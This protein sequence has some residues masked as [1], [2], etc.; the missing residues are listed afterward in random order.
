MPL[1]GEMPTDP[2]S[3]LGN[4]FA[5]AATTLLLVVTY[6][7]TFFATPG[8]PAPADDPAYGV[9]RTEA[10]LVEEPG[11]VMNIDGP[12]SM[13]STGYRI[14]TPV[15][16]ALMR[17]ILSVDKMTPSAVFAV[18]CRVVIALLLAG[19]AYLHL[20]DIAVWHVV[21]IG[22]GS[23]LLTP[24]FGGYT[25]NMIA[26]ALVT[27]SLYLLEPA[28][29]DWGARLAFTGLLT[30]AG[31]AHPTTLV[32][33]SATLV[34]IALLGAVLDGDRRAVELLGVAAAA[35]ILLV[36][37]RRGLWGPPA[38]LKEAALPPPGTTGFFMTRLGE[39]LA[40]I[41]PVPNA[42]LLGC[43]VAGLSLRTRSNSTT[44]ARISLA[45]LAPLIGV[46][47]AITSLAYPYYRFFNSTLAW[48]LLIG[49]G[50]YFAL[51]A[52]LRLPA[53]G[54]VLGIAA[55]LA[56]IGTNFAAG[57]TRPSWNDPDH[58]WITPDERRDLDALSAHLGNGTPDEVIFV[59]DTDVR[60]PVRLYGFVKR[61]GN[62]ARY[63]VPGALQSR[64]SIYLGSVENLLAGRATTSDPYY[65]RLSQA[66]LEE[67]DEVDTSVD[68]VV[69]AEVF[70]RSG[71]NAETEPPAGVLSVADGRVSQPAFHAEPRT[72]T[73]PVTDW[74]R[75]LLGAMLM[76]APG[77]VLARVLVPGTA[78]V[79]AGFTVAIAIALVAGIAIAVVA[80]TREPLTPAIAW[81]CVVGCN[82]IA[83]TTEVRARF[84]PR[85]DR[86]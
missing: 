1:R 36:A 50:G 72:L 26:L 79:N 45:W 84:R 62:I 67:I 76:L 5:I 52:S 37:W 56:V 38:S 34:I 54:R 74:A 80:V 35:T 12:D 21:A 43:G 85:V 29:Q 8:R 66:T 86:A 48:V 20:R 63:G 53:V 23:I 15:V 61:S 4:P 77:F 22:S 41:Q 30:V 32:I 64:T 60:E 16:S 24:P 17:R 25:D 59:V 13:H 40:A 69:V 44:F 18:A 3:V 71:V 73:S 83:A 65:E 58:G 82:V 27:A 42:A 46:L 14:T 57:V 51:R 55:V 31:L 11:V 33:F 9:W 7:W 68:V 75:V 81:G 19:F 47:G 6:G 2:R 70:N 10:L 49:L 28:R 39:W 78:A